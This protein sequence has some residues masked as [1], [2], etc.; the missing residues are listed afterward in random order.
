MSFV[1]Q[2]FVIT[3]T[4]LALFLGFLAP[5]LR[6]PAAPS[7]SSM[8]LAV[9]KLVAGR[10]GGALAVLWLDAE[11]IIIGGAARLFSDAEGGRPADVGGVMGDR[12]GPGGGALA[13]PVM[14]PPIG[15]GGAGL[16]DA[17][18]GAPPLGGGGVA[19]FAAL[20]SGLAFLLTQRFSSGS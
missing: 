17:E 19:F 1:L 18:R 11:R 16:D 20:S 9:L 6:G 14:S 15:G 7:K 12:G 5:G 2:S 4:Y 10:L 13:R 3:S 8:L